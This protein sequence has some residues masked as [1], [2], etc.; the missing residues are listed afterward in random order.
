M[1]IIRAPVHLGELKRLFS[2]LEVKIGL[3]VQLSDSTMY[4]FL[5]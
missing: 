4:K 5:G 1:Q 3:D 2:F